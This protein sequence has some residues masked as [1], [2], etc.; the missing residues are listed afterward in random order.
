MG[1]VENKIAYELI[2]KAKSTIGGTALT[3]A[4]S[5]GLKISK[6]SVE[7]ERTGYLEKLVE[8]FKRIIG[9]VAKNFA[10]QGAQAALA[11]F[12]KPEIDRELPNLPEW[13]RPSVAA[14]L[15]GFF[16]EF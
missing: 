1:S 5:E 3:I 9:P 16:G 13:A 11:G 10:I 14:K 15:S 2:E 7:T 8:A 12:E 6:G 4:E